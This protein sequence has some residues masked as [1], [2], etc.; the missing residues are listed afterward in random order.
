MR[1]TIAHLS[2]LHFGSTQ[3][4]VAQAVAMCRT[5][6]AARVDHVV[7][8]GDLADSGREHELELFRACF[9]ELLEQGRLT[10]IP[11]NHDRLGDDVGA[12]YMGGRRV[13]VVE[14]PGTYLV[15]VDSTGPHNCTS[16]VAGHGLIC[17]G[18]IGE[19]AR[20]LDRAP[21]GALVAMLVHHH[22][23]V[24]PAEGL[25][26]RLSSRLGLPY[27]AEL[28]LGEALLREALGRCD[29]VLHGHRHVPSARVLDPLG[30]RPLR[31]Y[32]AGRSLER[33]GVNIFTHVAGAL[34]GE[35]R[36]LR[37]GQGAP[38]ATWHA[39]PYESTEYRLVG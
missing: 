21:A 27:A 31:V 30:A 35:P 19:V 2:D 26:E 16:V 39:P 20:A 7:V 34:A 10:I 37:V 18:V 29:L 28:N 17:E 6:L 5:L 22:P 12:T 15:R 38:A 33:Q 32:N 25:L 1:R 23:V 9:A 8:T 36:W 4:T 11:G 24:L 13:D 3:T 14:L